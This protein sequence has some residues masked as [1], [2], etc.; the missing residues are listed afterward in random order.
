MNNYGLSEFDLC[1]VQ[2]KI[3]LQRDYLTKN[4][5]IT[6]NGQV[7]SLLDLSFSANHSERYYAQLANKINTMEDLALSNGLTPVFMTMTLDGFYRDLLKGDYSRYDSFDD[8]KLLEIYNSTPNNEKLGFIH[9]KLEN[10][11]TL[12]IKD[13]YKILLHQMTKFRNSYAFR[14]LKKLDFKYMYVRTVEP[15]KD[16]VPHFHMMFF[17]PPQF[18]DLFHKDFIKSFPA[19]RNKL[20]KSYQ[21]DIVS[22]SAYIMKYITKT[23]LDVKNKKDLDYISAWFVK[24]R[25]MRVVTSR[26]VVP[27]W[28]Y[29]ICAIFEK[30][31]FYLTDILSSPNNHSEWNYQEDVFWIYDTWL[32]REICYEYGRL[33]VYSKGHLVK[34]AGKVVPKELKKKLFEKS[35]NTWNLQI[36]KE[37]VP[38]FQDYKKI[39]VFKD[40]KSFLYKDSI[41][42]EFKSDWDIISYF[43]SLD[44]DTCNLQHYGYIKNTL[45]DRNLLDQNKTNLNDYIDIES[46]EIKI[47]DIFVLD[48]YICLSNFI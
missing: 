21:K 41:S 37:V 16:G 43:K 11:E 18:I 23:F 33:S 22:A 6:S 13:L 26:S 30:D 40:G 9:D 29:K 47:D 1:L 24:H 36:K 20:S 35:P 17:I 31:W 4:V 5:L 46:F 44:V 25:I 10:R 38:I 48:D 15:H 3:N 32:D 7:K 8:L 45:I 27:Q 42:P 28:I 2:E 19:P 34:R 39:G 14:K 12:T